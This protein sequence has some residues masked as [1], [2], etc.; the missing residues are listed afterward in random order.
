ME[1]GLNLRV[2]LKDRLSKL[3]NIFGGE[4]SYL[5]FSQDDT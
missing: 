1:I 3:F 2:S 4:D 5:L